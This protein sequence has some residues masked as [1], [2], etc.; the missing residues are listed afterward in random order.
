MSSNGPLPVTTSSAF[1]ANFFD[2]ALD[3]LS[4]GSQ[5]SPSYRP[6]TGR[7]GNTLGSDS[8]GEYFDDQRRPSIASI[9]TASSSGSKSSAAR[10]GLHK[11]LHGFFGEDF[12]GADASN[13]GPTAQ[14]NGKEQPY[15]KNAR[16][17][18]H[19]TFGGTAF[20]DTSPTSSRPRTPVPPSDVVPFLYQ[21]SQVMR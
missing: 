6:G 2:D 7:T 21:D 13:N 12:P 17:Q 15:G 16:D 8:P 10:G 14:T 9:T 1:G 4:P 18:N 5:M 20:G 19:A 3:N 11:K